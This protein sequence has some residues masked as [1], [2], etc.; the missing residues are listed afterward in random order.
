MLCSFIL[1]TLN[2]T[3]IRILSNKASKQRKSKRGKFKHP[4]FAVFV[5]VFRN[6]ELLPEECWAHSFHNRQS[7]ASLPVG[8]FVSMCQHSSLRVWLAKYWWLFNTNVRKQPVVPRLLKDIWIRRF[9]WGFPPWLLICTDYT[10]HPPQPSHS[11]LSPAAEQLCVGGGFQ[12]TA[13]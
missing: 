10:H 6:I 2:A 11:V 12:R 3:K 8:N 4:A 7:A 13:S 1:V 9:S 5:S